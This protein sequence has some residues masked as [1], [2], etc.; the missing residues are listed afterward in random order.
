MSNFTWGV[1]ASGAA[2]GGEDNP[3]DNKD[4]ITQ[5]MQEKLERLK[6]KNKELKTENNELKTERDAAQLQL[7]QTEQLLGN[8]Q[9]PTIFNQ[10]QVYIH[11]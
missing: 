4:I 1:G 3:M 5:E 2:G 7:E 9:A 10:L 11:F 6:L 8:V